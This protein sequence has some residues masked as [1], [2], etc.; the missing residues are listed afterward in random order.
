MNLATRCTACGTIFRVVQDQLRVSEGWVRCGRCA[1]VFDAREQLFDLE[2]D[3]PPPWPPEQQETG[4]APELPAAIPEEASPWPAA[5]PTPAPPALPAAMDWPAEPEPPIAIQDEPTWQAP[6]EDE[7]SPAAPLSQRR[8]PFLAPLDETPAAQPAPADEPAL[9]TDDESRAHL[10][11]PKGLRLPPLP[12]PLEEPALDDERPDVLLSP[13][14]QGAAPAPAQENPPE[15]APTPAPAT[16]GPEVA[17]PGFVKR[18]QSAARWQRPGVRLALGGTSLLLLALL[19]GQLG[20]HY[21]AALAAQQPALR[22]AL[23]AISQQLG[24]DLPPWQHLDGL[25]VESSALSP[26]GGSGHHYRLMLTLRNKSPWELAMPSVDLR[27]TDANGQQILRRVLSPAELQAG[28]TSLAG[29]AEQALQM[30]F[31]TG[32]YTVA[33][34]DIELVHP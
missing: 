31:S 13:A 15:P 9:T 11:E 3:S 5:V 16:P 6:E 14:L 25:G 23:Q 12:A 30:V 18:A 7:P 32:S 26:A 29:G 21:R 20:W 19:V 17:T 8:E 22:P 33:G 1:E 27:L 10:P 28:R 24:Q 34:Y 4:V 2:H